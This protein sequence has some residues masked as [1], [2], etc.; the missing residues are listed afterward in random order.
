MI[1]Y[2]FIKRHIL[3]TWLID[4][5]GL[6]LASFLAAASMEAAAPKSSFSAITVGSSGS[7][8]SEPET[9]IKK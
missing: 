2:W 1:T 6:R 8:Q 3:Q 4:F 9:V 5:L 7:T